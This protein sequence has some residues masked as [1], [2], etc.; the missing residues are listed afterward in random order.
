MYK[1][2][3]AWSSVQSV[4]SLNSKTDL[5][6]TGFRRQSGNF[7]LWVCRQKLSCL[8]TLPGKNYFPWNFFATDL[9]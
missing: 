3:C 9:S 4:N 8:F 7:C 6:N 2:D 1:R 5:S